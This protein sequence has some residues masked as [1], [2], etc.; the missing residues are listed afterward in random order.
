MLINLM[1]MF[2]YFM[3]HP[4]HCCRYTNIRPTGSSSSKIIVVGLELMTEL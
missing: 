4:V 1:V 2:H 3:R